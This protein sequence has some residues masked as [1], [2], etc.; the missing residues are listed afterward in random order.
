MNYR[1]TN[2]LD[3]KKIWRLIH[4]GKCGGSTV[5]SELLNS[6]KKDMVSLASNPNVLHAVRPFRFDTSHYIVTVRHPINRFISAF[7]HMYNVFLKC[8]NTDPEIIKHVEKKLNGFNN[9][10]T[11]NN[12]AEDLYDTVGNLNWEADSLIKWQDLAS[13]NSIVVKDPIVPDRYTFYRIEKE[14]EHQNIKPKAAATRTGVATTPGMLFKVWTILD[15]VHKKDDGSPHMDNHLGMDISWYLRDLLKEKPE[16][17]KGVIT[18]ENMEVDMK[19]LFDI[20][21]SM[22]SNRC[23]DKNNWG[24]RYDAA[25]SSLAI[26]NLRKYLSKDYEC[27]R[28]LRD[29]NLITTEYFDYCMR[30]PNEL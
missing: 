22:H 17:I 28:K 6:N 30:N 21:L 18:T 26:S 8:K 7:Y 24:R 25:L 13:T 3:K 2:T 19:R 29:L 12:L 23:T 20:Q 4:I 11:A 9:Y 5:K 14:E 16:S 27:L 1:D 10:K 15:E